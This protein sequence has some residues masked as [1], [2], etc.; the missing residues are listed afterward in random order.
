MLSRVLLPGTPVSGEK[1]SEVYY[2]K[3]GLVSTHRENPLR[4]SLPRRFSKRKPSTTPLPAG[5]FLGL[6]VTSAWSKFCLFFPGG[7]EKQGSQGE[8]L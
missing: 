4:P 5:Q 1:E 2:R 6:G 3:K 8:E 7:R